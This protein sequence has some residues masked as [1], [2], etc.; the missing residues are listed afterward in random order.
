LL[1]FMKR[2]TASYF[3]YI[4]TNRTRTL[5]VGVTNDLLRRV[6]EHRSGEIPGFTSKYKIHRLVYFE[7]FFDIRQ[8]IRGRKKLRVGC[9]AERFNSLRALIRAGRI[10]AWNGCQI[11]DAQRARQT[12]LRVDPSLRSV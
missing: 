2:N 7:E 4:L 9:A 1:K 3:V 8:A 12:S 10:S 6:Y 11:N 5:Y